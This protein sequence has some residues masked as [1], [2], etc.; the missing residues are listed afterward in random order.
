[1]MAFSAFAQKGKPQKPAKKPA[2][3]KADTPKAGAAASANDEKVRDLVAFFQLL[4]NTLGSST[5]SARDKDV[6]ITESYAKIFRDA[7]VQIEDDLDEDRKTI[8]NKDV[9]AYLKDVDFFFTDARFEFMIDGIEE[10]VNA[11]NQVFYKVSCQRNL[12]GTTAT[13]QKVNNTIPRFIEVNYDAKEND[14]KIVSVYTNEFDERESLTN[15]WNSLSFEWQSI[16]KRRLNIID[17]VSLDNIKDMTALQELDLSGNEYIQSIDPLSGL[18]NLKLLNLANTSVAD[19]TPIRNLTELV[20][21]NLE[22]TKVFDLTPLRYNA[23]LARLNINHTDVRSVAVLEKMPAMQN[24]QMEYTDVIDFDPITTLSSIQNLDVE[25]TQLASLSPVS[26]LTSLLSLKISKT[27]VQDLGPVS[28]LVNLTSLSIDSTVIRDIRPLAS[29]QNLHVLYANY[30]FFK[31]LTPLLKLSQL[32]RVYC[33]QTPV[34]REIANSFMAARPGVLVIYDSKDLQAWWNT[35]STNWRRVLSATAKIS[36]T[37]GKEELARVTNLDSVNVANDPSVTTLEALRKLLKVR[38][39]IANSTSISDLSPLM[40]LKGIDYV[41]ISDT[42]V[43]DLA[44]LSSLP[45]LRVVRADRSQ[46]E[47]L[48]PLFYLKN[49]D[50]VYVDRTVIHDITAREFLDKNPDCLLV[51]KTI[52]LDRWWKNLSEPWKEVFR[53]QMGDTT[54]SRENLH[55]LVEQRS[56]QFKEAAVHDLSAFSEFV[57]LSELHF[58]AT[59]ITEIPPLENLLQLKSLH[60]THCPLREIGAIR[61]L[62]QLQ[63]L[64]ISN[65]PIDDLRGLEALENLRALNCSGTQIKKL[66]P[67]EDLHQLETLDCSITRVGKLDPVM[68][69][70]LRSLKCYNTKISAREIDTFRK[71]NPDCNVIYYR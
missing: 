46:I 21:L 5:T 59:G 65:T 67:L 8:T 45:K 12:T 38:V 57:R 30:T 37:P 53:G 64:D 42:Q 44:P 69:L 19:L 17:S 3:Q 32:Q 1:M 14:L 43:H 29:L 36:L 54:A 27:F 58:S 25:G 24:L 26:A 63:D 23:K 70:S 50:E 18:N 39:I 20:E 13:G 66:D 15:W 48:D 22:G 33:D 62:S 34:N 55:K 47:K 40:G 28:K 2:A 7:K 51:Y 49:L 68:Y 9:V 56:F 61:Q 60:A 6:V 31:D 71:S 41:D 11:N 52:H 35:L 10:G 16:F 4:L